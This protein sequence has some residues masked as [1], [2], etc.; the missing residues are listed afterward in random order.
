MKAHRVLVIFLTLG[1]KIFMLVDFCYH[2][3]T[4]FAKGATY[5]Y[6][7]HAVL[8]NGQTLICNDSQIANCIRQCAKQFMPIDQKACV[9][10]VEARFAPYS[11]CFAADTTVFSRKQGRSVRMADLTVGDEVLDASMQYVEVIGW[12]HRDER[13]EAEFWELKHETGSLLVTPDHMLFCPEAGDYV[14][15]KDVRS[16]QTLFLDGSF[17]RSKVESRGTVKRQGI[18]APLTASGSLMVD[19]I[20]AS[21]YAS[22]DELPFRV[23]QTAGQLALA[24]YRHFGATFLPEIQDYCRT[25]YSIF[26]V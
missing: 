14:R 18:F 19:G 3:E 20:H 26:A 22:P 5:T 10:A 13:V 11:K 9:D 6:H 25:L 17:L 23:S 21:C 2:P 7:H 1:N 15:A 4:V 16:L 24:P 8:V 12:L